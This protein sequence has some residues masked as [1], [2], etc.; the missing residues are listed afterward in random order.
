MKTSIIVVTYNFKKW[1]NEFFEKMLPIL[2]KRDDLELLIIE[3][4]SKDETGEI[5]RALLL[6]DVENKTEKGIWV[7]TKIKNTKIY[8]SNENLF[9]AAGNNVGL[10]KSIENGSKYAYWNR[11]D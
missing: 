3:N 9:F 1:I 11:K 10:K 8:F 6:E 7:D 2:N 4:A 5:L